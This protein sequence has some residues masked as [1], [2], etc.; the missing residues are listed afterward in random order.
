VAD[1]NTLNL[2]GN[3]GII[4]GSSGTASGHTF[5]LPGLATSTEAG[6]ESFLLNNNT[7]SPAG[8]FTTDAYTE[9]PATFGA[10]TGSGTSCATPSS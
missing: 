4:V 6:A 10:F 7:S 3:L 9:A 5:N 1:K 8:G 2:G